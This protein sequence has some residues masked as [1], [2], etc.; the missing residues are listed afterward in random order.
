MT[1]EKAKKK[2]LKCNYN[3]GAWHNKYTREQIINKIFN[4][5]ESRTCENCIY[6]K[7]DIAEY[8]EYEGKCLANI[9]SEQDL[10]TVKEDFGCNKFERREDDK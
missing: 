10:S 9:I 3:R 2:L 8:G 7:R 4:D 6:F 1:R 5:F